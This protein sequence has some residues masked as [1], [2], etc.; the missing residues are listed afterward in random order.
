MPSGLGT[1]VYHPFL[2]Q[3]VTTTFLCGLVTA[4]YILLCDRQ[5]S[6]SRFSKE[7]MYLAESIDVTSI[8]ITSLSIS[9]IPQYHSRVSE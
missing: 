4:N 9:L 8:R 1:G 5:Y 2:A 3:C 6:A 7:D